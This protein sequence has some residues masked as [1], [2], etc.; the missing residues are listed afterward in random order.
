[1][2]KVSY[3][4]TKGLYQES[5]TGTSGLASGGEGLTGVAY[6]DAEWKHTWKQR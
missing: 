2:P 1:M 6:G 5:G 3:T 4:N